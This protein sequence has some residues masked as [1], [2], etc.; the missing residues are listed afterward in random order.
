M[1]KLKAIITA[2]NTDNN[3]ET[4]SNPKLFAMD[5]ESST[6]VQGVKLLK[7]IPGS[8]DAAGTTKEVDQNLNLTLTPRVIGDKKIKI[9]WENTITNFFDG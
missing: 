1:A 2:S 5:G 4:I 3:A 6:L 9:R 8:G 7:V